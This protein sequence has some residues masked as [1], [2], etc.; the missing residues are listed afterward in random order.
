MLVPREALGSHRLLLRLT[1]PLTPIYLCMSLLLFQKR[2]RHILQWVL[3]FD[4][5]SRCHSAQWIEYVSSY[6]WFRVGHGTPAPSHFQT[7]WDWHIWIMTFSALPVLLVCC[8]RR[9]LG[10]LPFHF[11]LIQLQCQMLTRLHQWTRQ[12]E[13]GSGKMEEIDILK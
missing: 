7:S 1:V 9:G 13:N 4:E 5:T 12:E 3:E 8:E 10:E 11:I 6:L 2:G